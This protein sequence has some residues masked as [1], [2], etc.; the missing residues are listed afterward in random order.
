[1]MV[2]FLCGLVSLILLRTLRNDYARYTRDD[3]DMEGLDRVGEDSGWKQIHGDVFRRPPY[4]CVFSAFIGTG[5]QL[6]VIVLA[7]V[8]FAILGEFHG[9]VYEERGELITALVVCYAL[10]STVAGYASGSYYKQYFSAL[11]EKNSLWQQTMIYTVLLLP[12][13]ATCI[14]LMLNSIAWYIHTHT[15]IYIYI[16][17][18]ITHRILTS[19]FSLII[20]P[21]E[22]LFHP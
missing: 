21:P 4:L 13:V 20:L 7:A 6:I 22:V 14:I 1:M 15:H 16:C 3:D 5:A 9:E 19:R 2:I 17:I 12:M 10:S 11:E 8:L 18:H